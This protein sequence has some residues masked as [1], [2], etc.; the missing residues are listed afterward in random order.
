MTFDFFAHAIDLVGIAMI[1]HLASSIILWTKVRYAP[2]LVMQLFSSNSI[3]L[4]R[5][6]LL[7]AIYF[8]PWTP[9]PE[10]MEDELFSVRLLFWIARISGGAIPTLMLVVI[11][12]MFFG[13][14]R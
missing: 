14:I 3:G 2:E 8:A 13:G 11:S 6:R 1:A 10:G 7:R 4:M 5:P 9:S 12:S